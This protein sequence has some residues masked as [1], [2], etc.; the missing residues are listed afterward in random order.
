MTE[1]TVHRYNEAY[2]LTIRMIIGQGGGE[3]AAKEEEAIFSHTA[4]Y[5][6]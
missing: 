5:S 2:Y 6:G 1:Q 4:V 3:N